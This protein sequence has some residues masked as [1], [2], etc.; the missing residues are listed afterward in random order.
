V[1]S[2]ETFSGKALGWA[3]DVTGHTDTAL[4]GYAGM[5][6][7]AGGTVLPWSTTG[8]AGSTLMSAP[9]GAGLG[10]ATATAGL[11]LWIPVTASAGTYNAVLTMTAA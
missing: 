1:G 10:Q 2:T 9:A 3:P 7:T 5:D 6:V 11:T 8:I 4:P